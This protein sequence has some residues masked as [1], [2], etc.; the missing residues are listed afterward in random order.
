MS[1]SVVPPKEGDLYKVIKI[2][3]HRFELRFGYYE[4]FERIRG[5]PVVIYPN[6]A[7]RQLFDNDGKRIV[8]AVQE[9]CSYYKAQ[10]RNTGDG[11]CCDCFHYRFG[12]DIGV[13]DC[14]ANDIKPPGE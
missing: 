8:T 7:D 2:G 9:P 3:D 10:G 1:D 12:D 11:C 14:A 4:E 5:E 13:C 6:L